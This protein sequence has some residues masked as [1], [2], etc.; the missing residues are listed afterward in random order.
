MLDVLQKAFPQIVKSK[1]AASRLIEMIPIW[2][3]KLEEKTFK[4]ALEHSK[5]SLKL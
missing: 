1:E 4:R 3:E 2:N 5:V